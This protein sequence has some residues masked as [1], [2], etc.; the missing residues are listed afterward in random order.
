MVG[1]VYPTGINT[2]TPGDVI[3]PIV[4]I[5][6]HCMKDF[7]DVEITA[8]VLDMDG[9]EMG[10]IEGTIDRIN[11][12]DTLNYTFNTGYIVPALTNYKFIVYFKSVDNYTYNDTMVMVCTPHPG[13]K[14]MDN[15]TISMEQNFPNPAN[16]S[17]FIKYNVPQDGEVS[18]KVYSV[19]GQLLY[20]KAESVQSGEHQIEINTSNFAT[21]IYFYTMEFEGQR[22]T[23]RM[24][25][26]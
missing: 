3:N 12:N 25:K 7:E 9:A 17:T 24:N 8:L 16:E 5:G 18:F 2:N 19:S 13:I 22:I 20:N 4:L 14:D 15:L 21:G 26:Q 11:M 1:I 23:K 10:R 6:N